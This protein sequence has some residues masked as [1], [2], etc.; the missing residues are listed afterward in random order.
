MNG[1]EVVGVFGRGKFSDEEE[2]AINQALHKRLGPNYVSQVNNLP[3][4][5]HQTH[6]ISYGKP[7]NPVTC[8]CDETSPK[9]C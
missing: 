9:K 2:S 7:V 5:L 3:L 1:K 6:L 4:V 8:I